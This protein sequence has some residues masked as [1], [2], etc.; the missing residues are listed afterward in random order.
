MATDRHRP[1]PLKR[2]PD[3]FH[4][5]D[6]MHRICWTRFKLGDQVQVKPSSV[7]RLGMHEKAATAYAVREIEQSGEHVSQE[8]GTQAAALVSHVH[9]QPSQERHRL[10][11]S[12]SPLLNALGSVGGSDLGHAPRVIGYDVGAIVFRDNVHASAAR[13]RRLAGKAFEPLGLLI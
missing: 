11:V 3:V 2:P 6:Q 4:Q 9:T 10:R 1:L 13:L 8:G 12:S 5:N 7:I